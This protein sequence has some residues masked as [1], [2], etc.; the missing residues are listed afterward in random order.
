MGTEKITNFTFSKTV[1]NKKCEVTVE[2]TN[3]DG[4]FDNRDSISFK[5][6]SSV[7]T[8]DE[9]NDNL[10]QHDF[11]NTGDIDKSQ[12]QTEVK[13]GTVT[14][15]EDSKYSLGSLFTAINPVKKA[16]RT[17]QDI[18]AQYQTAI[19]Q[20]AVAATFPGASINYLDS[21]LTKFIT[22]LSNCKISTPET[23]IT[24]ANE[25]TAT[26]PKE[27]A[28][29]TEDPKAA[30]EGTESEAPATEGGETKISA[31]TASAAAEE[32][33]RGWYYTPAKA[34]KEVKET[35]ET[36]EIPAPTVESKEAVQEDPD[37]ALMARGQRVD[38]RRR[39]N[40]ST[41]SFT[42]RIEKSEKVRA[43]SL[44]KEIS[45]YIKVNVKF[46]LSNYKN[47]TNGCFGQEKPI[48][49]L[50]RDRAY[51]NKK[52]E[53]LKTY[54]KDIPEWLQTEIAEI[55]KTADETIAQVKAD[56]EK[57]TAKQ[58]K[59]TADEGKAT[60]QKVTAQVSDSL[61]L[62]SNNKV[63]KESQEQEDKISDLID[64]MNERLTKYEAN[65]DA[66]E[67]SYETCLQKI[68]KL[69]TSLSIET[70]K[71]SKTGYTNELRKKLNALN[72]H[73]EAVSDMLD[74]KSNNPLAV[75]QKSAKAPAKELSTPVPQ[76][77]A[78]ASA[79]VSAKRSEISI[80]KS[81]IEK[82]APTLEQWT[83][84]KKLVAELDELEPGKEKEHKALLDG[85]KAPKAL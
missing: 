72:N 61:K 7:F 67:D 6:D 33:A 8:T 39:D 3:N 53:E 32:K 5:G 85:L 57:A 74:T 18:Q 54:E 69:G 20:A 2:D 60:I 77:N 50:N 29:G 80:L 38:V 63:T 71:L 45:S 15:K 81:H 27:E 51:L 10:K 31:A 64:A 35:K 84:L 62:G 42:A 12:T 52:I 22:D 36:K 79:K 70:G 23:K 76:T 34:T 82:N 19:S 14:I 26:A 11:K 43:R 78:L 40:E 25:E 47:Y 9:I 30:E 75:A 17:P 65:L 21:L 56:Q 59:I 1:N 49:L 46:D 4:I 28:P 48:T 83:K 41:E 68:G 16:V 58:E 55:N 44:E 24:F 37:K 73:L 13:D 66:R